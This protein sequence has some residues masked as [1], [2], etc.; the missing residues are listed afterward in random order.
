MGGSAANAAVWAASAGAVATCAGRTGSDA[1]ALAVSAA[2]AERGVGTQIAVDAQAPTGSVARVDG[3]LVVDRGANARLLAEDVEAA[4]QA[5]ALLVSGYALFHDDTA[6]AARAALEDAS[7]RWRAVDSGAAGLLATLTA[8]VALERASGANALFVNE[9]EA[10]ILVPGLP[11]EDAA[12]RLGDRFELVCV[13][14][15]AA[16]T[17]G[18]RDGRLVSVATEKV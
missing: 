6:P 9:E 4:A 14:L 11:P 12:R 1:A 16:G 18:V 13:K 5:D 17:I 2:L 7:A 8:T 3:E 15:G 10:A